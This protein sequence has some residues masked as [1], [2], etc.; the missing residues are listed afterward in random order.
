MQKQLS[1]HVAAIIAFKIF[2][3]G[4]LGYLFYGFIGRPQVTAD[5]VA[6]SF[7]STTHEAR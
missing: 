2:M 3:L 1:R 4:A 6:T 5:L 7:S